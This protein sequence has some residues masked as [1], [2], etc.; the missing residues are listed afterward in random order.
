MF[1]L[2]KESDL[3][4]YTQLMANCW[5]GARWFGILRV[6]NSPFHK[7]DPINPNDQLKPTINH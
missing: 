3:L 2:I 5:F 1:I 4:K 6:Y 7:G